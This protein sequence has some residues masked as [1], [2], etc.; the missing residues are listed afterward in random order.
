MT[1]EANKNVI[2]LPG[3]NGL[4]TLAACGVMISHI[5]IALSKLNLKYALF[6]FE[7]GKPRGWVLGEHGVT[8]FF[9]LSGFLITYLLLMEK[10]KY[11]HVKI[12]EFYM[13]RMLRIWPLYYVYL[14][15]CLLISGFLYHA[16]PVNAMVPFYVFFL[17]NIPFILQRALLFLDHFWSIGVEE[18]F[19]LFWPWFFKLSEKKIAITAASIIV[20]LSVLR[21]I[22]WYIMPFSI[23]ALFSVVNRFDCMLFGALGAIFYFNREKYFMRIVDNPYMQTAALMILFSMVINRFW[24]INSIIE[25]FIVEAMTL[26]IIVGQINIKHRIINFDN[27]MM[28]YLGKLSYGIYVI[29]VLVLNLIITQIPWHTITN[30][31]A[32][33]AIIY[34][35]V[36][37][38]TVF[39]AHLSYHFLEKPFLKLKL[40]FTRIKSSGTNTFDTLNK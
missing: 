16:N 4:R 26:V 5:S 40:K 11:Q 33:V 10:K 1:P 6:G 27:R 13:R 28:D 9:V 39:L 22:L 19:Y 35:L 38:S 2:F 21:I 3:L 30:Q 17:A 37:S 8:M 14:L 12:K 34:L 29:H 36:I 15:I 18:Q 24:F 23:P 25:I 20:L 7:N 32:L 31:V